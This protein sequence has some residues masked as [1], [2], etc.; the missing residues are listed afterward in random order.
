MDRRRARNNRPVKCFTRHSS[1]QK[2]GPLNLVCVDPVCI[3]LV[4]LLPLDSDGQWMLGAKSVRPELLTLRSA[5]KPADSLQIPTEA[6][7]KPI[8]LLPLNSF[9]IG[10]GGGGG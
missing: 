3:F 8:S 10:G 1:V 4:W 2:T 9:P 5:C 7:C 6:G